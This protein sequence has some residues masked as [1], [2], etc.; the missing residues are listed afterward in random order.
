MANPLAGNPLRTR[1]DVAAGLMALFRP[2]EPHFSASGARVAFDAGA[3]V[4]DQATVEL[5]GFAR[6]LWGLAPYAA[7]GGDTDW[8]ALYRAGLAAGTDPD[9]PDYWGRP[10][11]ND[12]RVPEAAAIAFA[13]GVAEEQLWQPL[14]EASRG[15]VLDW[16]A[17]CRDAKVH[18]NNWIGFVR[19]IDLALDRLDGRGSAEQRAAWR[20]EIERWYLGRGWYRDGPTRR[21]DHYA[22]W[23]LHADALVMTMLDP[24][25]A[26]A[27]IHRTASQ[28]ATQ[29]RHW[30]ATDGAALPFGRSLTYRFAASTFW[31]ALAFAGVEALPW[32]QIKHLYLSQLR[33]W[34]A[35]PIARRD[36]LLT[37]GY[38]YPNSEIGDSYS[39]AASPGWAFKAFL[40][41]ALRDDHPF[42]VAEE[43][44]PALP[45]E[46]VVL[47]EPGMVVRHEPGQTI[48][49]ATGQEGPPQPNAPE[50]YAK[51]AYS[52]RHGF[53]LER[54]PRRFRACALDNMIGFSLDGTDCRGRTR[55]AD[56]AIAGDLLWSRW[57]PWQE[58]SVESWLWWDGPWQMRT[59]RI[60]TP[61]RLD[62][63]EGGFAIPPATDVRGGEGMAAIFGE[64]DVS[65]IAGSGRQGRV[66]KTLPNSSIVHPRALV[67]QLLAQVPPGETLFSAAVLCTTDTT[68]AE[69]IWRQPPAPPP[70]ATLETRISSQGRPIP[71]FAL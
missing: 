45:A 66:L 44:Q 17:L 2:I 37:L 64:G 70:V 7:G 8:C 41:L 13:L 24:G 46:P 42:W 6:P 51:F 23:S 16:L 47:A 52:T 5:E 3:A 68:L 61:I 15:R 39:S 11:D 33:W 4:H 62:S 67:P 22:G 49:L 54:D 20:A 12:Q 43:A 32:G 38:A 71:V 28:F 19:L 58:V 56:A 50:A 57:H 34:A 14:D 25:H 30:F 63:I 40:P 31:G 1:E 48:A 53:C 27:D 59:H 35:Q 21:S 69:R 29:F 18:A 9:H 65:L 10:G 55:C 26:G 36:G 60:R